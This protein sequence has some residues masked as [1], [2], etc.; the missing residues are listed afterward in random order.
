MSQAAETSARLSK[1]AR[2]STVEESRDLLLAAAILWDSKRWDGLKV[3]CCAIL[4]RPKEYYNASDFGQ[5]FATPRIVAP[6]NV[7]F[8]IAH[9][10][11]RIDPLIDRW[12][13][14][15]TGGV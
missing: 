14:L 4:V 5:L 13:A 3:I 9:F 2:Q 12:H 8:L 15:I 6:A 11:D 10:S 7:R 1:A